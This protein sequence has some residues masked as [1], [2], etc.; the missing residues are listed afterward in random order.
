MRKTSRRALR[1]QG[2]RLEPLEVVSLRLQPDIIERC[3]WAA[4]AKGICRT[5]F[6]R[7]SLADA[8]RD[9]KPPN[10]REFR[11]IEASAAESE[12][13]AGVANRHALP[14]DDLIRQAMNQF[15]DWSDSKSA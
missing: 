12:R 9:A 3:Q 11:G 8:T 1:N 7:A 13:W 10:G 5:E 2:S 14:L 4:D 6:M 15:C